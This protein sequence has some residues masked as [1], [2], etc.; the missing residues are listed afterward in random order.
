MR[1]T[2]SASPPRREAVLNRHRRFPR[3]DLRGP[4]P[5]EDDEP[6]GPGEAIVVRGNFLEEGELLEPDPGWTALDTLQ[7][8]GRR[9]AEEDREVGLERPP[10]ARLLQKSD[11]VPDDPFE[12]G[13][14]VCVRRIRVAVT[15]DEVTVLEVGA[16]LVHV[17]GAVREEKKRLRHG[18]DIVIVGPS[19]RVAEPL[20]RRFAR[21][22]DRMSFRVKEFRHET[23]DRRL[24]RTV[25][26][27][28]GDETRE[29]VRRQ[30]AES[31]LN[32]RRVPCRPAAQRFYR[33]RRLRAAAGFASGGR[34]EFHGR[35]DRTRGGF[36][37]GGAARPGVGRAITA[38]CCFRWI[39]GQATAS[40]PLM[41]SKSTPKPRSSPSPGR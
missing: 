6:A 30:Q 40:A 7:P 2:R 23:A 27:L 39:A 4:G 36:W 33:V 21:E 3:H 26:S 8:Q 16:D 32:R 29:H 19:H 22:E 13:P 35:F 18:T 20:L 5:I 24:P 12:T 37:T 9:D 38:L 34:A 25:D 1:G 28:E 41:L 15:E 31:T 17:C 14:L 11:W 10:L